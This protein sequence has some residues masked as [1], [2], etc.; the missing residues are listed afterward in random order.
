VRK[1]VRDSVD[2]WARRTPQAPAL[3]TP[4][5]TAAT[6]Q[7]LSDQLTQAG[8]LLR[9]LGIAGTDRVAIVVP[10]GPEALTAFLAVS[11]V[12]TAAPIN[13]S[14]LQ[15][16]FEAHLLNVR[17]T[18][19]VT[20]L[21]LDS[22]AV[23]AALSLGLLVL[24]LRAG[25]G[26]AGAFSLEQLAASSGKPASTSN[27]ETSDDDVA[28]I[29]TTSGTTSRPKVVPLTH[30]SISAS[31]ISIARSLELTS[32][33]R[34]VVIMPLFHVHGLIGAALSSLSAGASLVCPATGFDAPRFFPLAAESAPTWYTAA[35]TM[36]QA[37][38]SRADQH[39]D[40]IAGIRLRVVRSCSAALP[41]TTRV[42]LEGTF[43]APVVEAYGMTEAAHQIASTPL[44]LDGQKPGSVGV[45]TGTT[46]AILDPETARVLA[47]GETG[48]VA[49]RGESLTTG[50]E[51]APAANAAAFVDGWFRTG[52][53]G[54][55]D[56]DGYLFLTGRLKE[57]INRGG[58]KISPAEVDQALLAHPSIAQACTF[59]MPD[60]RLGE[61]VAAAVVLKSGAAVTERELRE[62]AA[63]RIAP[64]KVPARVVFVDELPKTPTG[65]V[66]RIGMADRLGLAA[67]RTAVSESATA[68]SARSSSQKSL[69]VRRIVTAIWCD[70][71]GLDDAGE[72]DSFLDL[73]GDSLLAGQILGRVQA[74]LQVEVSIIA[75]FDEPTI[76]GLVRNIERARRGGMGTG[77]FGESHPRP[78]TSQ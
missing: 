51:N 3:I 6:Y 52:D 26:P 40:L 57:I 71:L 53:Q 66:Q 48:E 14:L 36:H 10:D 27:T 67:V 22:P 49:I 11:D 72:D 17:A 43:R 68:T 7:L 24:R 69:F 46:I 19:L 55:I 30:A 29:L 59:A 44:Q 74:M 34:G 16:E 8:R 15:N 77:V 61:T 64:F 28:L 50:Y 76:G 35:P 70:V 20:S 31:A 78:H 39:R 1:R 65:K 21:E 9:L 63:E 37:I 4:G 32:A 75:L 45:P 47:A 38:V 33:D 73:G 41:S 5:R 12:A 54:R 42:A 2:D 58:E 56:A 13:P 25:D 23:R 62:F 18:S 60:G